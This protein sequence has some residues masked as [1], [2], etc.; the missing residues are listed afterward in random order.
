MS[1][2]PMAFV[3]DLLAILCPHVFYLLG[4][5]IIG[6][7]LPHVPGALVWRNHFLATRK[8]ELRRLTPE[9][10]PS[11]RPDT[12]RRLQLQEVTSEESVLTPDTCR[13]KDKDTCRTETDV[14]VTSV[15][16]VEPNLPVVRQKLSS[17]RRCGGRT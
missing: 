12:P 13:Q 1:R 11:S 16:E 9:Y 14:S 4:V 15:P 17:N 7:V 10:I 5:L 8:L 3:D 6:V 2:F